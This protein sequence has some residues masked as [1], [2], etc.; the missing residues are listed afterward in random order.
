MYLQSTK[1][2]KSAVDT[3]KGPRHRLRGKTLR[4]QNPLAPGYRRESP[5]PR[6][7]LESQP[8]Y[9]IEAAKERR[10]DGLPTVACGYAQGGASGDPRGKKRRAEVAGDTDIERNPR[11]S[12]RKGARQRRPAACEVRNSTARMRSPGTQ[13]HRGRRIKLQFMLTDLGCEWWGGL[14]T[15][16]ISPQESL[17]NLTELFLSSE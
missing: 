11:S 15:I 2:H 4:Q 16:Q 1:L 3:L 12:R 13:R 10:Q 7:R 9:K 6:H 8:N 14:P 5:N 17:S